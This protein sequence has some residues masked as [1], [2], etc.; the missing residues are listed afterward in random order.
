M[1]ASKEFLF[2]FSC[3]GV[4][5]GLLLSGY[6]LFFAKRKHIA[7]HFLAG[8][9]LMM[10]IR[11]GKSALL[12][13]H[14]DLPKIYLQ[15]GLSACFLIGPF[16]F[17]FVSA[18]IGNRGYLK[19]W[20]G[21]IGACFL[22]IFSV[23]TLFTYEQHAELWGTFAKVIYVQW[24]CFILAS[25]YQL[26]NQFANLLAKEVKW[27]LAE[28]WTGMVFL[29]NVMIFIFYVLAMLNVSFTS[30]ILGSI[31]FTFVAYLAIF[32]L[33]YRRQTDDL[34]AELPK[35]YPGREID[36]ELASILIAKLDKL[37][38]AQKP[39][40]DANLKLAAL[41]SMLNTTPHQLSQVLN[42]NLGKSFASYINEWRIAEACRLMISRPQITIEQV[43]YEVGFNAK[44]TFFAAFKKTMG[45]TPSSY[46]LQR[47]SRVNESSVL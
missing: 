44:S 43:G 18:A 14:H 39:Y 32:L 10:C 29:G 42:S 7:N 25:G 23:G 47:I 2:F 15:I 45:T 24:F 5:N 31:L 21:V 27:S 19:Y 12:Y 40:Q 9:L 11:I 36:E 13:F 22:A 6:F 46:Q 35:R 3:L 37:M 26:R 16:L 41:A 34:F 28:R 17:Y 4:F 1:G 8:L 30:Y 33:M 20:K 38:N